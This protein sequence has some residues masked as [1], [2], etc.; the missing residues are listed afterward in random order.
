MKDKLKLNGS[1]L[2]TRLA[3]Y[4]KRESEI[5]GEENT[6]T[7]WRAVF[8]DLSKVSYIRT[9]LDTSDAVILGKI[10]MDM[11][12][13]IIIIDEDIDLV[14]EAWEKIVNNKKDY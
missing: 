9:V 7:E 10:Y 6:L 3:V 2:H 8:V 4:D 12:S 5:I 11:P 14:Y 1:I 13:G